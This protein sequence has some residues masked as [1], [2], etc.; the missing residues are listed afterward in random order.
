MALTRVEKEQIT[1]TRLKVQAAAKTLKEID[2]RKVPHHDEI[3]DCL[4]DADKSLGSAL[5]SEKRE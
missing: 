1:D 4:E 3:E 5:R 2:A